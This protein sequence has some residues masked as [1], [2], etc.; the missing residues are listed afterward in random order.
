MALLGSRVELRPGDYAVDTRFPNIYYVPEDAEFNV[1]QG[2]VHWQH[3]GAPV[4]LTLRPGDVYVLPSGYR[5]RLEKQAGGTMWRLIGTRPDA[6]LC[7]KPSTVSGGGKSEIS[8]S[9]ATG[10]IQG[11]VFVRDY[12]QDLQE[13]AGILNMDFSE[14]FQ[15]NR[16]PEDRVRRPILS[17]DRSLG[18]VIKL[19]TPSGDYTAEYNHW[20]R[21]LPQQFGNSSSP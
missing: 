10:I 19:L 7:H 9:I 21:N 3:N 2:F 1:R 15:K 17:L 13:V 5:I 16:P 20:L 14:I 8:K 4:Q 18:S 11:P 6:A 12:F